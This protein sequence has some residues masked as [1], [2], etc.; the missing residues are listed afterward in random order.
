MSDFPE[1]NKFGKIARLN[2]EVV[3]T[4]KLDGTNAQIHI[5]GGNIYAGSRNKW[6]TA[7]KDNYGFAKWVE[8]NKEELIKLGEGTHYGEWY[9][10]GI[11]RRY[12]LQEKRLALFNTHRW[13]DADV[14]PTC[15]EVVTVL[16]QGLFSKLEIDQTVE[17]LRDF[18]SV[19]VKGFDDPEGVVVFH[20]H[21][22]NLFKVTCKNDEKPKGG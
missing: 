16:Y 6:I 22:G 4:E 5:E 8:D 18:G 2:R 11:Q 3:I 7:E 14:R 19:H 21:S 17:N 9:G 15:C 13:S 1:F 12:G 20:T 10:A